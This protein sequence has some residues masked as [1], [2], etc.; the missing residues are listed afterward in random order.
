MP[1]SSVNRNTNPRA[2][3]RSSASRSRSPIA[4][5]EPSARAPWLSGASASKVASATNSD[6]PPSFATPS[7]I[8]TSSGFQTS[9]MSLARV[10]A[11]MEE[12]N[13]PAWSD[14]TVESFLN[15]FTRERSSLQIRLAIHFEVRKPGSA[16]EESQV[17]RADRAIPVLR[18]DDV[19]DAFALGL[20][21]VHIFA[22][23]EC[24][25]VSI[26]LN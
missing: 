9:L 17:Y 1:D 2:T 5:S 25:D 11:G 22:I 24:D 15:G 8:L 4:R 13:P 7:T 6:V 23:N 18:N 21:I 26:L 14:G 10:C 20:G 12:S 3:T 16:V 19:G